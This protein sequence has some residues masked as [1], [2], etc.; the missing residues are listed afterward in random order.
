MSPDEG[1]QN[2]NKKQ[3]LIK[4]IIEHLSPERWQEYRDLR[5]RALE[6]EPVAFEDP[7]RGK[8]RLLKFQEGEWRGMLDGRCHD[9]RTRK[10]VLV[11]EVAGKLVGM[12]TT[13]IA[14]IIGEKKITFENLFVTKEFRGKGIGKKLMEALLN[15][16]ESDKELKNIEFELNVYG[17][18]QSAIALYKSLGLEIVEMVKNN[19]QYKGQEV[20]RYIM[21][22]KQI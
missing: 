8:Q 13:D 2:L 1:V 22:K 17:T 20:D 11:A 4:P 19:K 18:Q 15:K 12:S 7:V 9:G 16:I 10:I 14:Q 6:E 5:F 3:E 21:K